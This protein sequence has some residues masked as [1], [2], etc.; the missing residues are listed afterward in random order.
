MKKITLLTFLFILNNVFSQIKKE[1]INVTVLGQ[2]QGLL[3]LN[4]KGLTQDKQGYIWAGT[5]DGLH[6]FNAYN[7]K[8][9][10]HNPK[11]SLSIK[12]DHIRDLKAV[13]DTLFIATNTQGIIGYK[14]SENRFFEIYKS[15]KNNDL[16]FGHVVAKFSNKKMIFSTKNNLIIYNQQTKKTNFV[17]LPTSKKENIALDF[18]KIDSNNILLA[19]SNSGILN[20]NITSL[21]TSPFFDKITN[22]S[23]I[24]KNNE[25]LFIGTPTGLKIVDVNNKLHNTS[26]KSFVQCFYKIADE[27]FIGT[28]EG[29]Y[30]Y[31]L[32]TKEITQ[33]TLKNNNNETIFPINII[34]IISDEK[35]NIWFGTEGEGLFH[36]SKYQKKFKTINIKLKEFPNVQKISS[37]NF[38]N[39][40]D[41]TLWI[42]TG[43]GMIKYYQKSKKFKF[44]NETKGNLIYTIKKDFN[45]TIWA[46]GFSTGLLK[47]NPEKDSFTPL[48]HDKKNKTTITDNEV[49]EI[50]PIDKNTLWVATWNVGVFKF[51]IPSEKFTPI[52]I[53]NKHLSRTRISFVDSNKN[54]W[55]GSDEGLYKV[56]KNDTTHYTFE[57]NENKKISNNRI[58]AIKE[59]SK[60]NYWV[61]T[62]SGLTKIDKNENTTRY[63]KQQ[64]LP[65]DFIYSITI[66]KKDNVWVS[67]NHGVSVLDVTKNTFKNYT[68]KDGLQ[69]IEFNGKAGFKDKKGNFYFGGIGGIN[70]FN[71]ETINENPHSPKVYIESVELFNKP[72][73]QNILF[74]NNLEF[75]SSENVLTFNYAALNFINS[76]KVL[77]QYKMEGFDSE[78][79]PVTKDRTTT[80]TNLNPGNYIF[81]IKAT[82]DVGIW[83]NSPTTLN[84]KITP[85]WYAQLWFRITAFFSVLFSIV[86]FY[87]YKTNQL[88]REKIKLEKTVQERTIELTEKNDSLEKSYTLTK[89]QKE[90]IA[91]LMKEMN[92]RVRNNLQIISSLLNIQAN[93]TQNTETK[94]ILIVAKNRILSIAYIQSILNTD[95]QNIDLCDFIKEVSEKINQTLSNSDNN[96]KFKQVYN[97][98]SIKGYSNTNLSLIGLILNEL[99]TNTH[100][101]A[102]KEY[103]KN[104]T[105]TI[106]CKKTINFIEIEIK[107]N[108]IGY[109]SDNIKNSSLGLEL[110]AEMVSQLNAKLI[111]DTTNGVSNKILIPL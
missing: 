64:G 19:T 28:K 55:L 72:I 39:D 93:S 40:H 2:K 1:V 54:I 69:N 97:I 38:L 11:D 51:D 47:Y 108:G 48:L 52:L 44:Y 107:D 58:F 25:T 86:L 49:I 89:K 65:N 71:P 50:I 102:F 103:S 32:S 105:L 66:D 110:I 5:E 84:I 16:L 104:N 31:S 8:Q 68:D 80:Y 87:F 106:S 33:I 30:K 45:N 6:K 63:Y 26:I 82:N 53:K 42:G 9:F 90:N 43:L 98:Q 22:T 99:I 101:Y 73:N 111:T 96:L 85:P 94:G 41:S 88:K 4:I 59:D 61:G 23:A 18:F 24:Y 67:T 21:K 17:N 27:L 100:K 13:N 109:T 12:D 46:G 76:E 3:Q 60:G 75:K 83:N 29:L 79:R 57:L 35:G 14:F 77:Y 81:K 74:N 70:I 37:F 15:T 78:W 56:A 91:F 92:H 10:T 34:K 62:A 95:S 20:L 36:Y 7:F